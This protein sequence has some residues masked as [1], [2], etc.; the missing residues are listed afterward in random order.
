MYIYFNSK[1]YHYRDNNSSFIIL[2]FKGEDVVVYMY[3]L[4]G[5]KPVITKTFLNKYAQ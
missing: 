5:E 3:E 1:A 4:V 2:E